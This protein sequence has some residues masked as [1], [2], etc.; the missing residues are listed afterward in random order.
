MVNERMDIVDQM[1]VLGDG[2]QKRHWIETTGSESK[3]PRLPS[4]EKR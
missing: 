2:E 4:I 1:P 3:L